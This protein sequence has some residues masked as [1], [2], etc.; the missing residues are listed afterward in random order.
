MQ[1]DPATWKTIIDAQLMSFIYLCRPLVEHMLERKAGRIIAL[2]SDGGK[3]GE[4]GAAVANAG[5]AGLIGFVK[6]LAREVGRSG[7]TANLV[8]PGPTEGPSLEML[9]SRGE[10]RC[11]HGRGDDPA[12]ADEATGHGTRHCQHDDFPRVGRGR[13]HNRPGHQRER[14]SGDELSGTQPASRVCQEAEAR[15]S[16]AVG[17]RL[18]RHEKR[19]ADLSRAFDW[20][21]FY[22]RY[23]VPDV[24]VD[25]VYKWSPETASVP[26]KTS[27]FWRRCR[28]GGRT[29]SIKRSGKK[30]GIE[31]GDIKSL[32][33]IGKLPI[34]T[35]E[36]VRT[37]PTSWS[38]RRSAFCR[39]LRIS[40]TT[41]HTRRL[42]S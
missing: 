18:G 28:S 11:S 33:D 40:P 34:Y 39:G 24:F 15:V 8:C 36:D 14:R 30:A 13:I 23:P 3:V 9:R 6:S 31:P 26:C 19:A 22:R 37:K 10:L 32:D 1:Q 4:S 17:R 41:W 25:T 20:D 21:E 35:S 12:G 5:N 7:I 2:S 16:C 42:N 29:R 27:A 38:T